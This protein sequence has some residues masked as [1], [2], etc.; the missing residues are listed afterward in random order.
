MN[1]AKTIIRRNSADHLNHLDHLPPILRRVY[2]A[3]N[4]TTAAELSVELKT[5]HSFDSLKGIQSATTRLA[6][7]LRQQQH[8]LIV[9]DFDADGATSTALV[10]GALRAFGA[11][12]VSYVAPNRFEYGYGLSEA[13]V[14][15]LIL[16]QPDLLITVDNGISS[17]AG[18][19]KANAQGID[20]IVTDHHLPGNSLPEAVAIVNP[21]Q[22]GCQFPSKALAGVG[23]VFH[24]LIALR[25]SLR[26]L[27]WFAGQGI[28]E[29]NLADYLDLVALGTVADVVP[30]DFYNRILVAQGIKRIRAGRMRPGIAQLLLV[31]AKDF[32]QICSTDLGFTVGPRLNAAGRLDDMSLGIILLT[33]ESIELASELAQQMDD[34]NKDRRLI[35]GQMQKEALAIVEQ[36][37]GEIESVPRA[38]CLFHENWHQG[39]VGLVASRLKEKFHRPVIAFAQTDSV[40]GDKIIELKGSGRSIAGI[41]LRD[42]LDE[43]A[44]KNPGLLNKFGGHAM[45]AGLSLAAEDFSAFEKAFLEVINAI[46]DETIFNPVIETDGALLNYDLNLYNAAMIRDAMPWGQGLPEPVFEGEF[47]LVQQKILKEAH[48][49]CEFA[50]TSQGGERYSG[51]FFN[52]DS[53]YWSKHTVS[54][55]LKVNVVYRLAVNT[56]RGQQSLQLMVQAMR[57]V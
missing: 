38:L 39:V 53:E 5:L 31:A 3:R 45:A 29:P 25:K 40:D 20:V 8:I 30:L 21:N 17:I 52:I 33:T 46:E 24:L 18:V 14:D 35:E 19:A 50:L 28:D 6:Q 2:S 36:L 44:V 51:I 34:F 1:K 27:G 47:F 23:V 9:G 48:L 11:T 41:H 57:F 37:M 56:F 55:P 32:R 15:E 10:V 12:Q 16:Q 26:D 54:L 49:K 42:V 43:V 7:A 13:I 4:I 22:L